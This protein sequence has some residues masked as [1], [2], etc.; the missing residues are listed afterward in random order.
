MRGPASMEDIVE[1]GADGDVRGRAGVAQPLYSAAMD[2]TMDPES[3]DAHVR[4]A[5]AAARADP[6]LM[7]AATRLAWDEPAERYERVPPEAIELIKC[8]GT[9][10]LAPALD[11]SG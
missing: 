3:D 5:S 9:N 6:R 2:P 7:Q 1:R 10:L 11:L 8:G 4:P